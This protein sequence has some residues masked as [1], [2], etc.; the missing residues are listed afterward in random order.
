MAIP[1]LKKKATG[2]KTLQ[3]YQQEF[4]QLMFELGTLHY[5]KHMASFQVK[6]LEAQINTKHQ[7][8]DTLGK[9]ASKLQTIIKDEVKAK[10]EE[11]Q[12]ALSE[13]DHDTNP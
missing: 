1:F 2:P 13:E 3:Q 10:V 5:Q 8:A 4:N 11:G 9:E 7:L 12:K 6:Q